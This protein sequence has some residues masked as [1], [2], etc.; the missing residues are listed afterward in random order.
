MPLG[1][2]SS[3][4]EGALRGARELA[5]NRRDAVIRDKYL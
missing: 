1:L 4:K 2:S 3:L 5:K